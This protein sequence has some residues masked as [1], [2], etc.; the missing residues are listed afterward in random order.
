MSAKIPLAIRATERLRARLERQGG[1]AVTTASS[2]DPEIA[3]AA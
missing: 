3:G 2:M 1:D